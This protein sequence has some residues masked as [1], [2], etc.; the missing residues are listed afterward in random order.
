MFSM[1]EKKEIDNFE[2]Q[3]PLY[4]SYTDRLKELITELLRINDVKIHLIEARTKTVE[5]F[6]EKI[7][8]PGKSYQN[9]LDELSDLSGIRVIVYYQDDVE[10]V[11]KILSQELKV[12]ESE[13]SH[14]PSK[15]SPDQFGYISLHYVVKLTAQRTKLPEWKIYKAFR[16]EIQIRTVLQHSWAAVSHALQYKHESDV[17]KQLRRKLYRL[18]GL[19]ELA[20]EEFVSVRDTTIEVRSIAVAALDNGDNSILIDAL[21]LNEFMKRWDKI[22]KTKEFM[23]NIGYNFDS[24]IYPDDQDVL[25][26]ISFHCERIGIKSISELLNSIDYDS[27]PFLKRTYQKIASE[28]PWY[29]S[30]RF[31]LLLLLIRANIKDFTIKDLVET[32]WGQEIAKDVIECA[33]YDLGNKK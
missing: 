13:V 30:E 25:G 18:A 21:S 2:L 16:S 9:P 19:F 23:T 1:N 10:N 26:Q 32:G 27:E 22:V 7:R 33:V 29:V 15:Y 6:S 24:M 3:R 28:S 12:V 14:Q 20:D 17:P 31:T 8:R 5:S 11:A 4:V